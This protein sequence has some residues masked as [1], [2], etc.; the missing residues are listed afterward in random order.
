MT[1]KQRRFC[2][3]YAETGNATEAARKAGYSGKTSYSIGSRLLRNVEILGHIRELQD[4]LAEPRIMT[5]KQTKAILSDI[6]RDQSARPSDRV[7]A[8]NVLLKAAGS[9]LH[10]K[11]NDDDPGGWIASKGIID[12]VIVCLPP[13]D[14]DPDDELQPLDL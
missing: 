7:Q 10:L 14:P 5:I 11:P 2:E 4:Q 12:D 1:D 8:A 3:Y 13:I 6:V 9:Y